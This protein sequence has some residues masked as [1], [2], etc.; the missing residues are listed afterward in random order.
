M[1]SPVIIRG[2][3][4]N[5]VFIPEGPLPNIEGR[6]ELVVYEQPAEQIA[7]PRPSIFDCFG[8]A[9]HLRSAEDLDAQLEEERASWD[10]T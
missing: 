5:Q 4:C 8:K 7:E 2:T 10:D 9:E 6:A 3:F 1:D